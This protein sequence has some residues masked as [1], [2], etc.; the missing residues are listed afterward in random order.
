[1]QQQRVKRV[2]NAWQ[3]LTFYPFYLKKINPKVKPTAPTAS[4]P[5]PSTAQPPQ[6]HLRRHHRPSHELH[7]LDI[8]H[9]FLLASTAEQPSPRGV[10]DVGTNHTCL[11]NAK[12]RLGKQPLLGKNLV[13]VNQALANHS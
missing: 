7:A 10:G 9:V 13:T 1:M 8:T 6:H 2:K 5:S 11:A 3:P 4:P 12:Q